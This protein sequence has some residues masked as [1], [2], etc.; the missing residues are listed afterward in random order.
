MAFCNRCQAPVKCGGGTTNLSTHLERHHKIMK[1]TVGQSSQ[2][3]DDKPTPP[4]KTDQP[5]VLELFKNSNTYWQSSERAKLITAKIA[6]FIVKDLR[7][8][9]VVS[10]KRFCDL[11]KALDSRYV[12]PSRGYFSQTVIPDM[13]EKVKSDIVASL[14]NITTVAL[15]TDSWT[16]RATESFVTIT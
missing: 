6:N 5:T 1:T 15:T 4:I 8:F 16:S 11:V 2:K 10:N 12:I 7:P 9:S 13:Y 3:S 14:S